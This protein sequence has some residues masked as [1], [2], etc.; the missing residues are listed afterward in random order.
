MFAVCD[1]DARRAPWPRRRTSSGSATA[2]P[3]RTPAAWA[4]TRRC[5]SRRADVVDEVIDRVHRARRC[6]ALRRRGIDYRGVLYAG[7]ML[8]ADGPK[9]IE[10]NV[11]F[12]DPESPGRAAPARR[13]DLAALLAEAAAGRLRHRRRRSSTTPRVTVVSRGRG[14]PGVAP[15]RRLDRGARRGA[16]RRGRRRAT[17]PASAPAPT[18]RSSPAGGG[19]S[20]S[21]ARAR[22]SCA[23]ARRR[24][25][26]RSPRSRG[27]ACTIEPTSRPRPREQRST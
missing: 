17:A 2:T 6:A 7:L 20:T 18:G 15:D 3:G 19:C 11:R 22:P 25:R 4:R 21:G 10:Y 9:M 1:G 23:A 26:G 12:G 5:R 8:T 24:L 14:L 27:P 13:R 16:A